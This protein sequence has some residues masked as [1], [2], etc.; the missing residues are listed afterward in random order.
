VLPNLHYIE[1]L[2]KQSVDNVNAIPTGL[3]TQHQKVIELIK[4]NGFITRKEVQNHLNIGQTRALAI[5][6]EMVDMDLLVTTDNGRKTEYRINE[7][8]DKKQ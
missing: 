1:Q 4:D 3:K 2:A 6:K 7:I 5:V 8:F